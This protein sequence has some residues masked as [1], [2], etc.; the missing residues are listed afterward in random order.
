M[1]I[2]QTNNLVSIIIVTFNSKEYILTCLKAIYQSNYRLI[3]IIVVDNNSTDS[4][5]DLIS[6][7]YPKVKIIRNVK[8]LGYA[9]GNNA[10]VKNAQGKYIAIINP[11]TQVS[12]NWLKPL[13]DGLDSKNTAVCQPKIMLLKQKNLINCT[14]KETHFLGFEWLK[15]YKKEDYNLNSST[16]SSFSGSIFL[17]TKIFFTK[18]GGFDESFFM[19]YED[20]D[21]SWRTRLLG[22]NL[23]LI[24]SSLAFHDYKFTPN[25]NYQKT[26]QKFYFLERNRLILM[27]KNYSTRT[28]IL[29]FPAIILMELGMNIYFLS[30]GWWLEKIKGYIWIIANIKNI[31]TKR[32][33]IQKSRVIS[34]KELSSDFISKIN[35][36]EFDNLILSYFINPLLCTY[37]KVI[38][39]L[40]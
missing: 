8:N 5:I 23:L 25:E 35:Y 14:G 4:T 17:T 29:I 18:L 37:W 7:S 22:K 2:P 20:G 6:H 33:F 19:Y 39:K 10:G 24:S 21:F 38:K 13:V 40:I 11:D 31:E 9:E 15:D 26:K 30:K 12:P 3:E 34:D 36:K 32:S 16:I 1:K 28:L 27:I